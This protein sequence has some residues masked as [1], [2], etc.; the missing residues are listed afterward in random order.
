MNICIEN[1]TLKKI[2]VDSAKIKLSV[3]KALRVCGKKLSD[4][5]EVSIVFLSR[6]EIRSM[7]SDYRGIDRATDI[8]SFAFQ[9]GEGVGFTPFLLGDM[10]ICPEIVEKHSV[11][12]HSTYSREM[13][14]VIIHGML[15]LLGF[16]HDTLSER[17]EMRMLEDRIMIELDK[18]WTGRNEN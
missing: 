6:D 10:F 8:I 12:Y 7:N 9:D 16:N 1:Q 5:Y 15:H 3:K 4:P 14:F 18:N 17:R 11:K 13:L 2:P